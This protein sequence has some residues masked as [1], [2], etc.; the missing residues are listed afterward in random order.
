MLR[1]SPSFCPVQPAVARGEYIN[2]EDDSAVGAATMYRTDERERREGRRRHVERT[3]GERDGEGE[4]EGGGS[5]GMIGPAAASGATKRPQCIVGYSVTGISDE[6]SLVSP[7][8]SSSDLSRVFLH[9][10][11]YARVQLASQDRARMLARKRRVQAAPRRDLKGVGFRRAICGFNYASI[12]R[13]CLRTPLLYLSGCC[14]RSS[15]RMIVES[16]SSGIS[17]Q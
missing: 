16:S 12:L 14:R 1:V 17:S 2:Q 10:P 15:P 6:A 11:R 5:R 3:P 8:P 7:L 9:F 4:G 13:G